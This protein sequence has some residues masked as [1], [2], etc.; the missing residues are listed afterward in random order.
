MEAKLWNIDTT[1][2]GISFS[3]RH[4]VFAKV[5][6]RFA[7]WSGAVRLDPT[8]LTRSTVEV[9]IEAASID[10]GVADRDT[11]LRSADFF[12]VERFPKLRFRGTAVEQSGAEQYRLRGELTIRDVTREVVLDVEYGGQAKDPWGNTRAL[13]T[14]KTSVNRGDFGLNW[15]QVLEAGGVLVGERIDI[16]LEVQAV[17]AGASQAA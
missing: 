3:V 6:G 13:F 12:D 16:E 5:R 17:A 8:D 4:L 1:H 15:N 9:E 7:Q 10:T 14:A 2:S 11:H